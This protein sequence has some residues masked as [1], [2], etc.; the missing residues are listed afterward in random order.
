MGASRN[1]HIPPKTNQNRPFWGGEEDAAVPLASLSGQG[2]L[3]EVVEGPQQRRRRSRE[4]ERGEGV[5]CSR[6][7]SLV[8]I[9][10]FSQ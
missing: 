1:S 8:R 9:G 4:G 3:F 5:W 10:Y 7:S 6:S 2:S